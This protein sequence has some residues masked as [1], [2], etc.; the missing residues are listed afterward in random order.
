MKSKLLFV[1]LVVVVLGAMLAVPAMAEEE[2][3]VAMWVTGVRLAYNGRSSSGSD[4]VV[5]M[6]HVRDA[7]Y[8]AVE[9]ATVTAV[10]TL[11]DGTEVPTVEQTVVQTEETAFQGIASFTVWAGY[12][13]YELCVTDVTKEGWQYDASQDI[14]SCG[15]LVIKWPYAPP[16]S[17]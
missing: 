1:A 8:A 5:G 11:P 2:E 6:V 12:G 16:T 15:V 14:E 10:W 17:R 9:G 4:R 13:T 3:D 7:D